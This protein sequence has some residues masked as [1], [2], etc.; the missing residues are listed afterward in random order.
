MSSSGT[1]EPRRPIPQSLVTSACSTGAWPWQV[2]C[3][4]GSLVLRPSADFSFDWCCVTDAGRRTCL[5]DVE[6]RA[7][8][9]ASSVTKLRNPSPTYC[10]VACWRGRCGMLA[11]VGG[12]EATITRSLARRLVAI[13][14]WEGR[15]YPRLLALVCGFFWRHQNDIV[16]EGTTPLLFAVIRNI[17]WEVELWKVGGLF[18]AELTLVDR[19]RL[20]E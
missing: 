17:S 1:R 8:Q 3:K 12:I 19:W 5:R 2:P 18:R 9:H 7:L 10:L 14:A 11:F 15:G 13:L 6:F 20:G 4:F 16:F